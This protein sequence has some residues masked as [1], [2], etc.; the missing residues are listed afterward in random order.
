MRG[1]SPGRRQLISA[2]IAVPLLWA[3]CSAQSSPQNLDRLYVRARTYWDAVKS[4][5]LQGAARFV[6]PADR[7]AFRKSA[8]P[9]FTGFY[10]EGFQFAKESVQLVVRITVVDARLPAPIEVPLKNE[11]VRAGADWFLRPPRGDIRALFHGPDMSKNPRAEEA[12]ATVRSHLTLEQ[13]AIDLGT[14]RREKRFRG[15]L[16][17]R[18]TADQ[19]L[20]YSFAEPQL[21]PL[22]DVLPEL[23]APGGEIPFELNT[24]RWAGPIQ[25]TFHLTVEYLGQVIE[26]PFEIR[27]TIYAPLV[28][29]PETLHFKTGEQ[30]AVLT[31]SN[32]T[33]NVLRVQRFYSP[34]NS[35][36][37]GPVPTEVL[38]HN[39]APIAIKAI[40][41][42]GSDS[43][44]D[45]VTLSF[46]TPFEG[47]NGIDVPVAI[48]YRAPKPPKPL[49]NRT[50]QELE[51]IL[52]RKNPR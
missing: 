31:L 1:A 19:P 43:Q 3:V 2:I 10:I 40:R 12:A 7:E 13:T 30:E 24:L 37:A 34:T 50:P 42:I 16:R 21:M 15:A 33:D 35:F 45:V 36:T 8:L 51:Q 38:P 48:N 29:T 41:A 14:V 46:A 39:S 26:Y 25:K 22:H 52:R 28:V 9:K 11:W 23:K 27:A 18:C 5:D 32:N 44:F 17:F 6:L 4:G 47:M 20:S 49:S